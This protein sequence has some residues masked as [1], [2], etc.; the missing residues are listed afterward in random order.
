MNQYNVDR[1]RIYVTGVSMGG[2]TCVYLAEQFPDVFAAMMPL[3]GGTDADPKQVAPKIKDIPTW[4]AHSK[5]DKIVPFSFTDNLYQE[6]VKI[7]ATPKF[8]IYEDKNHGI[9][10]S[11]Y[12]QEGIPQG[13]NIWQWLFSQRK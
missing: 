7:G 5:D 2:F 13:E 8:T 1:A 3:C 4:F 11:F 9:A 6:M 10:N 12:R